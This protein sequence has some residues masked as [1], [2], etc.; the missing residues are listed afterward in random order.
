MYPRLPP[1]SIYIAKNVLEYLRTGILVQLVSKVLEWNLG[2]HEC[3]VNA[4]P[5]EPPLKPFSG[6]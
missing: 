4:L 2:L 6:P 5:T 3:Q 1:T